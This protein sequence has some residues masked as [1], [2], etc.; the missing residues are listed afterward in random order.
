MFPTVHST[1]VSDIPTP[2]LS[3]GVAHA[4][5]DGLC[6]T[7]DAAERNAIQAELADHAQLD[8]EHVNAFAI[9]WEGVSIVPLWTGPCPLC[10]LT[11]SSCVTRSCPRCAGKAV[12]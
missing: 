4:W 10:G 7:C 5:R 1:L 12:A 2:C 3:C 8:D 9:E 11:G 6:H